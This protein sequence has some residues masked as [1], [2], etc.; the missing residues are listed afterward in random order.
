[1]LGTLNQY[2]QQF[3][4]LFQVLPH[5]EPKLILY[6]LIGIFHLSLTSVSPYITT[7]TK[8]IIYYIFSN[9][10]LW[11]LK[12]PLEWNNVYFTGKKS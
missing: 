8:Y 11:N 3:I 4:L 7:I 10:I 6:Y 5:N 1:M 9:W 2:Y 12:I